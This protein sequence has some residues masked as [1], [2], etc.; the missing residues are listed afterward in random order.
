MYIRTVIPIWARE[1]DNGDGGGA[2][3]IGVEVVD[4]GCRGR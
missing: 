4:E 2:E 1:A 3:I